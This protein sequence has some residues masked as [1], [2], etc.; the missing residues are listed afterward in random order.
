MKSH[1]TSSSLI[2]VNSRIHMTSFAPYVILA[3]GDFIL[4]EDFYK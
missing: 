2:S 4:R 3:S 1:K